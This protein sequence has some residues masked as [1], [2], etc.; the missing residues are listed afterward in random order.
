[1]S[2]A[3]L[4]FDLIMYVNTKRSFTAQDVA[5]EFN[6]SLRTAHRYLLELSDLGIPIYTEQ[7]RKGGY[8][9]LKNRTLPPHYF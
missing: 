3:R 7:G 1:M 9:T 4:L 2:K 6:I 5:Y 8:R